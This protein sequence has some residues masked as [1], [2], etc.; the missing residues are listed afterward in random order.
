MKKLQVIGAIIGI[1]SLAMAWV[2]YGW[3][4]PVIISLALFGN[5]IEQNCKK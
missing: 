3:E 1:S 5:N 4:L 2:V